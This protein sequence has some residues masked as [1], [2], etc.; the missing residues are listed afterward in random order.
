MKPQDEVKFF[1]GFV[2]E[3]GDYDVLGKG[4]YKQLLWQFGSLCEPH[5]HESCVDCGCGTGAFTRRLLKF[6]LDLIGIVYAQAAW[7]N[8]VGKI[9][10]ICFPKDYARL[11]ESLK[12]EV[13]VLIKGVLRADDDESAPKLSVSTS[14]I[15]GIKISSRKTCVLR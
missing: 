2:E 8:T 10:I 15:R 6:D 9:D 12:I 5:P 1:D 13:P 7:K 11:C 14:A 4:A 3:H